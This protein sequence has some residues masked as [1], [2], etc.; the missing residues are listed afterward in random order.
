MAG[1]PST[2]TLALIRARYT[3][4]GGAERFVDRAIEAL[5]ERGVR[6]TVICAEWA[7]DTRARGAAEIVEVG[8]ARSFSRAARDQ[9]FERRVRAVIG[10]RR[11]DIVQTHERI[12]GLAVFRAGDGLHRTWLGHKARMQGALSARLT[13]LDPYHRFTLKR[14]DALFTHPALRAV[15]AN[16][17]MVRDEIA[18]AWP[19]ALARVHVIRNGVDVRHFSPASAQARE[20]A[21]RD[22]SLPP[23]APV[24]AFIG[25]GFERK[26]VGCILRVARRVPAARFVVVGADKHLERFR[27]QASATGVDARVHFAGPQTDV[28]PW[29]AA[30]QG[31]IFPTLYD[32]GPNAVLE[33]MACG[34]PV[35]TSHTCGLAEVVVPA[36]AGMAHD[37]LDD[38]AFAASIEA[39]CEPAA[40]RRM[41]EAAREAACGLDTAVMSRRLLALYDALLNGRESEIE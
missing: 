10:Q 1:T 20:Q 40:A 28:R 33:A 34:L 27:A 3:P 17:H 2:P 15:I 29:L 30:A 22:L 32:P 6:T 21:R 5:A 12:P 36:G 11:F 38:A 13:R 37:A 41:G 7:G 16:S 4:F 18:A 19:Q 39:L 24:F 25:S 8:R 31:F 23:D 26:G 9:E 35:I 14:E